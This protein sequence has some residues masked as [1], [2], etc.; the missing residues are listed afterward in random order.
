MRLLWCWKENAQH[1]HLQIF[2]SLYLLA[3][4]KGCIGIYMVV[5]GWP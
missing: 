5:G 2:S 1:E 3:A 4:G